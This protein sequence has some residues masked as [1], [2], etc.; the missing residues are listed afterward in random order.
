MSVRKFDDIK[1]EKEK[2]NIKVKLTKEEKKI[3]KE[4]KKQ[5]KLELKEI[6]KANKDVLA[7]T[8]ELLGFI[9]VD[10]DDSI[11]MKNGYLDIFQID[12]KDIYSLTDVETTMN[13]YNFIAF[14]RSYPFDIKLITMN[15]PVNT[16]KQQEFIKKKIKECDNEKYYYELIEELEQL[17]YLES[18][19]QNREFYIMIFIK[20]T[21][22]KESIKRTLFRSQ[23]IAVQL[24]PLTVE[25]KLKI[26]FKLNNPNTKLIN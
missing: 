20:D 26:L 18:T 12:S 6:R 4:E 24:I 9:D 2:K 14:L 5:K 21:E 22:E 13:I 23:N 1:I 11:I 15:F 7:S 10:D 8:K 3:K 17:V 16:L 19:R 25:K